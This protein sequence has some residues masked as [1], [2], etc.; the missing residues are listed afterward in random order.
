MLL[1]NLQMKQK[2]FKYSDSWIIISKSM[3]LCNLQTKQKYFKYQLLDMSLWILLN[4]YIVSV[5]LQPPWGYILIKDTYLI[6][7]R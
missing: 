1:C 2:Y 7:G 3:L 5:W 4:V 6:L